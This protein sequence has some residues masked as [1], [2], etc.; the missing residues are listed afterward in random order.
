MLTGQ[1]VSLSP[2]R[3]AD[4]RAM[5]S[6]ALRPG[7]EGTVIFGPFAGDVSAGVTES[8]LIAGA[9]TVSLTATGSSVGIEGCCTVGAGL[10]SFAAQ[11]ARKRTRPRLAALERDV[12]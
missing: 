8:G 11:A 6:F 3:I 10:A 2:A 4:T 9:G 12:E 7:T 5:L 1:R